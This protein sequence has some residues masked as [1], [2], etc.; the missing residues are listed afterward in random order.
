MKCV[1]NQKSESHQEKR[2]GLGVVFSS[3]VRAV[4][5]VATDN[6]GLWISLGVAIGAAGGLVLNEIK[7]N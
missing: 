1:M 7:S 4:L 6:V 3:A 2:M 5:G